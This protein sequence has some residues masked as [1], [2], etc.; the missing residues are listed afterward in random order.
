VLHPLARL[1]ENCAR[2]YGSGC[3]SSQGILTSFGKAPMA[4]DISMEFSSHSSVWGNGEHS[5]YG[6]I[7]VESYSNMVS[8]LQILCE[9]DI[10]VNIQGEFL[11]KT[12]G[13][14]CYSALILFTQLVL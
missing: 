6:N 13:C 12:M 7:S 11:S 10:K 3:D 2:S 5:S 4:R 1:E 14:P 9:S 8:R